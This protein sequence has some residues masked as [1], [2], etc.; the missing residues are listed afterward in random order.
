MLKHLMNGSS[1]LALA[2]RDAN[3]DGGTDDADAKAKLREQI[4]KG[5]VPVNQDPP[6]EKKE[7]E[8]KDDEEDEEEEDEED[9]ESDDADGKKELEETAEAKAER[10]KQEKIAAKAQRKQD[11]MQSR[12]DEA[13]A[14]KKNAEAEVARLKAQ[15]EANPEQKLTAEEILTQAKAIAAEEK[16]ASELKK[17]QDDFEADCETLQKAAKKI[18]KDFD[19]KVADMAEQFGPIPSFMI[20]VLTDLDN[21]AEVLAKIAADDDIA[22][23]IY[24][25]ARKPTKLTKKLVEIS[26]ELT[27]AKKPPKKKLSKV[28]DPVEPVR[29]SRSESI[30]LTE[31]D[32]KDMDTYV[33]KRQAQMAERRKIR[34]F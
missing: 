26:K 8:E 13:V 7:D 11:R 25:L 34:G 3:N 14:A 16:R 5:N 19:A 1:L 29:G 10:E 15:L 24:D 31:A 33:R 12:I 18:D 32:A 28:P 27:D 21:G 20:G 2:L 4:A 9:E 30:T 17:L 23:E 6:P 22:E